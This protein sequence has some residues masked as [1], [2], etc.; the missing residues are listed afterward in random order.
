MTMNALVEAVKPTGLIGCVGVFVPQDPKAADAL[1]KKGEMAFDFGKFWSK[2]MRLGT[3]QANVKA[4]NRK[5]RDLIQWAR[6]TPRSSSL[7]SC[8]S[9]RPPRPIST[10]ISATRA[11]L[12][13]S[14]APPHKF[15][16]IKGTHRQRGACVCFR[17]DETT[18]SPIRRTLRRRGRLRWS[19]IG[20]RSRRTLRPTLRSS[21]RRDRGI[22]WRRRSL[23]HRLRQHNRSRIRRIIP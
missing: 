15:G 10:L 22:C 2:G 5:L 21:R 1:A 6:S 12:R 3:G 8:R 9:I 13:S 16:Q 14:F 11:G 17:I 20:R 7:T 4:Y 23:L 19:S 18:G